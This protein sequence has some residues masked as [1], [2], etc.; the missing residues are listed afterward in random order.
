MQSHKTWRIS[1]LWHLSIRD[2]ANSLVKGLAGMHNFFCG[3]YR[4]Y[5]SLI[6]VERH[7]RNYLTGM[8]DVSIGKQAAIWSLLIH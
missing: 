5:G 4:F 1:S 7:N 6:G 8:N 2:Y 3:I